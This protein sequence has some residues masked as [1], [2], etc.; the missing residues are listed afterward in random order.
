MP[1]SM[2]M[3]LC[4]MSPL[5]MVVCCRG[6]ASMRDDEAG[7]GTRGGSRGK[8]DVFWPIARLWG[9]DECRKNRWRTSCCALIRGVDTVPP[10][11]PVLAGWRGGPGDYCMQVFSPARCS[12]MRRN[13]LRFRPVWRSPVRVDG[14]R[15]HRGWYDY[16]NTTPAGSDTHAPGQPGSAL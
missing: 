15:T 8:G 13:Q 1:V 10:R 14:D 9:C 2:A 12:S 5:D 6:H 3:M 4:M 11:H 16:C 7:M